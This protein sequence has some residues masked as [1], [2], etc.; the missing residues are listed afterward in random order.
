MSRVP[1]RLVRFEDRHPTCPACGA[2][3]IG[4]PIPKDQQYLFGATHFMRWIG[5]TNPKADNLCCVECPDC[6]KQF[7]AE[8]EEP[9]YKL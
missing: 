8:L 7:P 4:D 1:T 2:S 3:M 9:K 5:I 6:G